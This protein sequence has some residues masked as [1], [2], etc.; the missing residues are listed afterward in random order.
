MDLAIE[1]VRH[2]AR[3]KENVRNRFQIERWMKRSSKD[4]FDFQNKMFID[5]NIKTGPFQGHHM[6]KKDKV[7]FI[8]LPWLSELGTYI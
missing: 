5:S 7:D 3:W 8:R 6:I 4:I 2:N 1:A